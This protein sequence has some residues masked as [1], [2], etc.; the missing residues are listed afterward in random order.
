[1]QGSSPAIGADGTLYV[2]SLD[3]KVYAVGA[4]GVIKWTVETGGWVITSPAISTDD[5]ILVTGN[6]SK[7][8]ALDA[9][10]NVS[11]TYELPSEGPM[12]PPA[13]NEK[14]LVYFGATWH[15]RRP[16]S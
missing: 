14:D 10:G 7:L 8:Y 5:V 6:D 9:A 1:M 15:P 12:T 4:D 2:G 16:P 11:W 3:H 13:L